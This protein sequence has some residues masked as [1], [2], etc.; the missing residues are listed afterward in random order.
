MPNLYFPEWEQ[1]HLWSEMGRCHVQ[2]RNDGL[3]CITRAAIQRRG[4]DEGEDVY[5]SV[6]STVST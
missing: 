5:I 6:S 1:E 3:G 4:R 2:F